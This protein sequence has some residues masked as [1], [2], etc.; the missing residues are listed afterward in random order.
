MKSKKASS[1][2]SRPVSP[3]LSLEQVIVKLE[4][5]KSVSSP[6]AVS[7]V[8]QKPLQEVIRTAQPFI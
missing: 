3:N 5:K 2:Q 8:R 1:Q 7:K 6:L 4:K